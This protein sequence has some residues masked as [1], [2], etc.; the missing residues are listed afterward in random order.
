MCE[1]LSLQGHQIMALG[2][3]KVTG[4]NQ[5]LLAYLTHT[6]RRSRLG[7]VMLDW[8]HSVDGLVDSLIRLQ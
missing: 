7:V 4:V 1:T 8:F 6:P 5:R 2:D 3:G